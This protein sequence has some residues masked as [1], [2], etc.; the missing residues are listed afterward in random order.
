MS[1]S[2]ISKPIRV[3][4][5]IVLFFYGTSLALV[6]PLLSLHHTLTLII[7]WEILLLRCFVHSIANFTSILSLPLLLV[8]SYCPHAQLLQTR[9]IRVTLD[10]RLKHL[11]HHPYRLQIHLHPN[12]C[13]LL[14]KMVNIFVLP[15]HPISRFL[16]TSSLSP[17]LPCFITHLSRISIPK[18][19]HDALSNSGWWGNM[20]LEVEEYQN[21]TWEL[22]PLLPAK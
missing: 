16:S 3:I 2:I 10:H 12:P 14:F 6:S 22:V 21:E 15:K 17:S 19:V 7:L 5:A 9:S 13:L 11:H 4:V 1:F 8:H 18:T 20:E